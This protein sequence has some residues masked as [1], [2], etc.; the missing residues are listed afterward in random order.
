MPSKCAGRWD[1]RPEILRRALSSTGTSMVR[2][3]ILR[4]YDLSAP[5][6]TR[7]DKQT[8]NVSLPFFLLIKI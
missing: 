1:Q 3:R 5:R 4:E 8:V 6:M 2:D 7:R